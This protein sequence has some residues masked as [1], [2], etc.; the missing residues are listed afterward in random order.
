M[1][2]RSKKK[3]NYNFLTTKDIYQKRNFNS[4]KKFDMMEHKFEPIIFLNT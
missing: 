1:Y 2:L 3:K 4:S